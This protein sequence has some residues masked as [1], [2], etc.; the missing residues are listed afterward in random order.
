MAW[1]TS[2]RSKRLPSD[3]SKLRR[4]AQHR[5][6]GIC[7][8]VTNGNRCTTTGSECDHTTPGDNHALSNLQWLCTPHHAEKTRQ[9]NAAR[10]T[11]NAELRRRPTEP[12]PGR[13]P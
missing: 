12:H 7:E 10:N 2:N 4:T 13:T 6:G 9:E 5:A 11:A 1:D 8:W 3:W